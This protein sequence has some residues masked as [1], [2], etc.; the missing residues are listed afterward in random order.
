[1]LARVAAVRSTCLPPPALGGVN[2]GVCVSS[3]VLVQA[4]SRLAS[5]EVYEHNFRNRL[6]DVTRSLILA[7]S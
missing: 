4:G 7:G 6:G 1:M 2:F 5:L 3:E